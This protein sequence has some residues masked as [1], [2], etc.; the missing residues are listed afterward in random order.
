[1]AH[2]DITECNQRVQVPELSGCT[3][4]PFKKKE[5]LSVYIKLVF[6]H[7]NIM[8]FESPSAVLAFKNIYNAAVA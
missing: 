3:R 7:K 2:V 6:P 8:L 1:M 5:K 4:P